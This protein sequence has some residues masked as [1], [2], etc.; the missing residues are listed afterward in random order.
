MPQLLEAGH[1]LISGS[2]GM[3]K[4]YWVLYKIVMSLQH[5]YPCCYIDPKGEMY[6]TLLAFLATTSQGRELWEAYKQR[7]ILVNPITAGPWM[8]GFN[9]IAPLDGFPYARPDLIALLANALT[10]HIRRQSGFEL[11]EANRM[12]RRVAE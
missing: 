1:E 5:G 6:Q 3:G 7:I 11:A 4:S 2:I 10:S 8:V 9:A 12:V